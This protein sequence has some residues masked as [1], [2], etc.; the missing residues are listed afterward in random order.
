MEPSC[1]VEE[2]L[3]RSCGRAGCHNPTSNVAGLDLRTPGATARLIDVPAT[4]ED[5][6]C[7]NPDGYGLPVPCV[8]SDCLPGRKRIDLVNPEQSYLLMKLNGTQGNCGDQM[9]I[10]PGMLTESELTCL[11]DWLYPHPPVVR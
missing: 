3:L 1:D 10:V 5:I 8:P 6:T 11:Q 2:V 4:Y 9:P 7:P